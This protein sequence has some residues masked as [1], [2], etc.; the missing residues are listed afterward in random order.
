MKEQEPIMR[1]YLNL[2]QK[3]NKDIVLLET[4]NTLVNHKYIKKEMSFISKV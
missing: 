4:Y 2:G 3:L 1:L